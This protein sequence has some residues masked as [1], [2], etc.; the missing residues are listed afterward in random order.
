MIKKINKKHII[1]F[2]SLVL[3]LFF[4]KTV[5]ALWDGNFYDPG[6]TL[7]PEC[8]PTDTNCD[9]LAPLTTDNINDTV[10]GAGW[11]G[12]TS[13]AP[14]KNAVYDKIE[15]L[16]ISSHDPVTIS[17]TTNGLSITGQQ[18]SLGLS[19][20]TTIG[21]LSNTDWNTFNNKQNSLNG[22]GFVKISGTTISYD[23]ST[24]LT[25]LNGAILIDQTTPQTI[26]TTTNR[27]SKLW[28]TD[29][30]VTNTING[31]ISGNASTVTTNANLTGPITSIGNTTSI[32]SQTG[33]GSTFVMNSS[34]TITTPTITNLIGNKIYPFS[35]STTG[36]QINKA[37]GTTN[38]L[39]VDTTNNRIGIGTTTPQTALSFP[40]ASTGIS[41]YNT[42]DM[43]TNYEQGL[44]SWS[45]NAFRLGISKGGTGTYRSIQVGSNLGNFI[46]NAGTINSFT[47]PVIDYD[48][49][50]SSAVNYTAIRL[51]SGTMSS[52]S[53]GTF[54]AVY[55]NPAVNQSGTAGYSAL[56]VN[57]LELSTGS[58]TK[59]LQDWQ[60]G[61]TS[62]MALTSTGN[63]GIG[64][65]S[66][67]Y[68]LHV[69]NSSV[70]DGT[71]LLRL[72]DTNSTCDFTANAGA[73]S[74]GSDETLK[75]N[76]IDQTGNLEKVL[77]LR[78]VTYNWLTDENN[79][80]IKHGF[81]AQE[82]AN[83]MPELVTNGTWIDGTTKKFL[84]TEGMIPYVVG[85]IKELNLKINKINDFEK[86]NDW[87]DSLT[88][89]FA[90]ATNRITRIFTGEVCLTS[91]GEEPVC[92][93][94]SELKSLK[95]L[96]NQSN[97]GSGSV[98]QEI[99]DATTTK[100]SETIETNTDSS[101]IKKD[102]K[103]ETTES[104]IKETSNKEETSTQ[105]NTAQIE[106]TNN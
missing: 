24:Y 61:G 7:N 16:L 8:L 89:W 66:P 50:S 10:Y 87:R 85:S 101:V 69:G 21:A 30:T 28:S 91:P 11:N 54:K 102:T 3:I 57:T 44:L 6:E 93:N 42:S 103:E 63:L 14:S 80:N 25:S 96:I 49:N 90:N 100:D 34:P 4:S 5:F 88:A 37:D 98:T 77:S 1:I 67:S 18:I 106:D 13:H 72:Q 22:T 74:C 29:L 105:E 41:L 48:I 39:N 32:N 75:K 76:I 59:L 62:K 84:Q 95:E 53:S 70:V 71:V 9:V 83:I 43:T 99:K 26:G 47:G 38:I 35:D 15:S 31:S 19:S 79:I 92:L 68:L 23:N 65:N 36:I 55:I 58:G 104:Q 52:A 60:L 51:G 78:P 33:T 56:T 27:L 12:D 81:I 20:A 46:V 73:P 2:A 40:S 45:S 64:T 17:A 97:S 82:V 94:S 86:E